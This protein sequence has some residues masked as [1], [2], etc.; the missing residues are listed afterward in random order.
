MEETKFTDHITFNPNDD[1]CIR[2]YQSFKIRNRIS[3]PRNV[4]DKKV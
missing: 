1:N 2:R 3:L 4:W